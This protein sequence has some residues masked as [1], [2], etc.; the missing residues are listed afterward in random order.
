M[1]TYRASAAGGSTSGTSDR[2]C[3]ITPAAGDLFIV[4]CGVS[5]NTNTAP[6]C[7]D[8][9]G[10]TYS[11]I[12]TARKATSADTMSVFVRN[13]FLTNTTSTTVTVATGSNTSGAVHVIAV[14]GMF[15]TALDAIV[16]SARQENQAAG[17]P[18][19]AFSASA[20]T[21]NLTV[22]AVCNATNPAGMTTPTNWLE[23]QDTGFSTP[24]IGLETVTRDSGFTGTTVTWGSASASAYCS[25]IVELDAS[26][27]TLMGAQLEFD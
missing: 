12:T 8:N 19:P 6:T 27:M 17:T 10:G 14:S 3:T 16:K 1:A 18:A 7:S 4:V 22:G 25:L 21:G 26:A 23:R 9:N 13:Q 5:V 2:T 24:S 20:L 11:L 15:R